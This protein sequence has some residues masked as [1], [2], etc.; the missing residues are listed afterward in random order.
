MDDEDPIDPFFKEPAT[1]Y[2]ITHRGMKKQALSTIPAIFYALWATIPVDA[3]QDDKKGDKWFVVGSSTYSYVRLKSLPFCRLVIIFEW[4][5]K[6]Y[7]QR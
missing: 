5:S 2:I 4:E 6:W 1:M 3:C 7:V